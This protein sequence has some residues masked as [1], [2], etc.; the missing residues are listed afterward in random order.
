[1]PQRMR[2]HVKFFAILKDHAGTGQT[3]LDLKTA[4]TV[5]DALQSIRGCY[6]NLAKDLA[7]SAVAVNRNYVKGETVLN[8]GDELALIPP[9]SGG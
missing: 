8:D 5:A 6:P 9:V 4:S 1:M 3:E 2:I 7:R